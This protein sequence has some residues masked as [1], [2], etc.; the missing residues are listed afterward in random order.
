MPPPPDNATD[1]EAT[2]PKEPIAPPLPNKRERAPPISQLE[3]A[4]IAPTGDAGLSHEEAASRLAR[5]GRNELSEQKTSK[6]LVF[7]RLVCDFGEGRA[8]LS[9]EIA[10]YAY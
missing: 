1:G 10:F 5:F 3:E 7:L 9:R 4:H 6:W 2:A 8:W